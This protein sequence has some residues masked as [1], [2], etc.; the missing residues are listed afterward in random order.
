MRIFSF[1][2]SIFLFTSLVAQTPAFPS[3]LGGGKYT[4]GG[5]GGT[6]YI[7][8][9]LNDT[10]AGSLRDGISAENRTIIFNVS[11]I[12][13]LK[14]KLSFKK[15]NITVAGQTAPGAGICIAGYPVNISASNII[16]RYMRFRL[17][18]ENKVE[19]DAINCF[20][21]AY[22]NIIIDHCSMSWSI[23]ET[24]SFYDV[25]NITM[26]WC[27]ISESLY[28]SFHS[29]GKHGYGGIWGGQNSSYLFNLMAHHTSRI[30]R[31]NGTRYN[32][33]TYGDS[34][35]CNNNVFY[36]WGTINSIYGGEGGKYNMINNYYKAGPATPGNLTTSSSSN[37]RNRILNYTSFYVDG[38]DTIWG[39]DFYINGN[40]V[41]G[42]PD[43]T[44]DNWTKG[45][46]KDSYVNSA[47]LMASGRRSSA[48]QISDF[49][50]IDPVMAHDSIIAHAGASLPLRDTIDRRIIREVKEG[51]ATF[52]G[53]G[54]KSI[55]GTGITRPA[56]IIDSPIDVGGYPGYPSLP[57]RT[58]SDSDGMPDDW[59]V[60]NG[61]NPNNA[62]DRNNLDS[63]G[64]TMLERYINGIGS[65][66]ISST[67]NEKKTEIDFE[68][69]P[70]LTSG[71]VHISAHQEVKIN[72]VT[73]FD[74]LGHLVKQVDFGDEK[75][76]N[77]DITSFASGLYY[78]SLSYENGF[79]TYKI[80]KE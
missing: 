5:R 14:S 69:F 70:T 11:G 62:S 26:Q 16:I 4:T 55:T 12:I 34:L 30:P 10:G 41:F 20:S 63:Q 56:G 74:A 68:V 71:W 66:L 76:V 38:T 49:V 75:Q 48:Y 1:I 61:L 43:V 22:K 50:P 33:Q 2:I 67:K 28:D 46:Q 51:N 37:K 8:T 40:F 24:A 9:N 32:S 54:Y 80:V 31:F 29:K 64:Y 13:N 65:I 77:I 3:A 73:C 23:D 17:G 53:N 59:E 72:Q 44:Q 47:A 42:Y 57:P 45:V 39:G 36:N 58:D 21:G 79:R 25:K 52:E 15:N 78:V 27:I 60:L 7:V 6:V 19:D 35:E 18:D